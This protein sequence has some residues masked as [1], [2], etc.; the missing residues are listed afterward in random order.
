MY[1]EYMYCL[2]EVSVNQSIK[3]DC[4]GT[5]NHHIIINIHAHNSNQPYELPNKEEVGVPGGEMA[6]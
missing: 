6:N 4:A 5:S 3:E 1:C 2:K